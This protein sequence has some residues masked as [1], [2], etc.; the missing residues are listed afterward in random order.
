MR[1]H[2]SKARLSS[3]KTPPAAIAGLVIVS[4]A[5]ATMSLAAGLDTGH[6]ST[7]KLATVR[8]GITEFETHGYGTKDAAVSIRAAVEEALLRSNS[9]ELVDRQHLEALLEEIT[10]QQSG[11]TPT[12]T[13][14]D[15]GN[16]SN[17]D[18]LLFSEVSRV[19]AE[20]LTVTMRLVDV[21]TGKILKVEQAR[22]PREARALVKGGE[23]LGRRLAQ[24]VPGLT[25]V[26]M[27]KIA[28]GTLAMG[29]ADGPADERPVHTVHIDSFSIDELEVHRAAFALFASRRD[30]DYEVGDHPRA[31]A[32]GVSWSAAN[33]YCRDLGKRLPTEAE[34]EMAARGAEA[35]SYPWGDETPQPSRAHYMAAGPVAVDTHLDGASPEGV[36]H[37]AGNVAEWVSDWW[38]PQAY[39]TA[40]AP[41]PGGPAQGEG[42]AGTRRLFIDGPE[43]NQNIQLIGK[44]DT[45]GGRC[46]WAIVGRPGR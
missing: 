35:R 7:S 9:I 3:L 40:T 11:V 43:T 37:L 25:P 41:N 46:R 15:L 20:T 6:V 30:E 14:L 29:R 32:T 45:H 10:F 21:A 27:V 13:S 12:E 23:I 16:M 19:D 39:H 42:I 36:Q 31:P 5:W 33:A 4:L 24:L 2:G 22:L 1:S 38:D 8:L 18:I 34:W 17:V 26:S 28:S 44:G